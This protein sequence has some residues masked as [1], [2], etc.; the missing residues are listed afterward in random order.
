MKIPNGML[1]VVKT[2]FRW[3]KKIISRFLPGLLLAVVLYGGYRLHTEFELFFSDD[4]YR[5]I[6]GF[7]YA[8]SALH[9]TD[10]HSS[11]YS[12]ANTSL[13]YTT[14]FRD[15]ESLTVFAVDWDM[16]DSLMKQIESNANWHI[17]SVTAQDYQQVAEHFRTPASMLRP[18]DDIVFDAFFYEDIYP[19]DDKSRFSGQFWENLPESLGLN[20]L[21]YTTDYRFAFYDRDS[22]MF[23]CY[24]E[25]M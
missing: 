15:G 24:D 20:N 12:A 6:N 2:I 14:Y 3:I 25:T 17:T 13:Y 9:K 23:I 11:A 4:L 19:S 8:E 7:R 21:Q 10:L 16:R 18:S 1:K 22:G 5:D